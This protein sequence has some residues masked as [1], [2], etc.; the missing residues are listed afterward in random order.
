VRLPALLAAVVVLGAACSSAGGSGTPAGS[1]PPSSAPS[2]SST[3]AS[4]PGAGQADIPSVDDLVAACRR[5]LEVLA[6]AG[7]VDL[8]AAQQLLD[9]VGASASG[10]DGLAGLLDES[11]PPGFCDAEVSPSVQAVIDEVEQAAAA[12]DVEKAK[13][14]LQDLMASGLSSWAP[15]SE[16]ILAAPPPGHD[17]RRQAMDLMMVAGWEMRLGDD[18][19]AREAKDL[20]KDEFETYLQGDDDHE[21]AIDEAVKAGDEKALLKLAAQARLLGLDDAANDAIDETAKLAKKKLEKMI[22]EFDPCNASQEDFNRFMKAFAQA[23]LLGLTSEGGD[24]AIANELVFDYVDLERY[25]EGK[26]LLPGTEVPL[27]GGRVHA[28]YAVPGWSGGLTV[29]LSSCEGVTWTGTVALDASIEPPGGGSIAQKGSV[30]VAIEV[31]PDQYQGTVEFDFPQSVTLEAAGHTLTDDK[32]THDRL[33]L[34]LSKTDWSATVRL[35]EL[36]GQGVVTG[37]GLPSF[38][39]SVAGG[40]AEMTASL[41]EGATCGS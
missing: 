14:M 12:G 3:T 18:A 20:A 7:M 30:D 26:P 10:I 2:S 11:S 6:N 25:R 23:I 19:A 1:T 40:G 27:C 41:E 38:L 9:D 21:G 15:W 29:D 24:Y 35:E 33:T 34:I 5:P 8:E 37:P 13:Q 16:G 32:V 22:D 31:D 4:A 39:H 28:E 17:H 36:G